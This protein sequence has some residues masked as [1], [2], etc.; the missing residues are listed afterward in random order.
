MRPPECALIES[1]LMP[2]MTALRLS[3]LLCRQRALLL[4]QR[5]DDLAGQAVRADD[6]QGAQA[7]VVDAVLAV[8]HEETVMAVSAPEKTHLQMWQ[9]ET[10]TA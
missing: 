7:H 9:T 1:S 8:H 10:A 2:A 6:G 3:A 4:R 5:R